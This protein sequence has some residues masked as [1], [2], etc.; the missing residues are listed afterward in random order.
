M[1]KGSRH[2]ESL[3]TPGSIQASLEGNNQ[4]HALKDGWGSS[5]PVEKT[6]YLINE[7]RRAVVVGHGPRASRK[8]TKLNGLKRRSRILNW[9]MIF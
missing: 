5:A 8:P 3:E 2:L 4:K 6:D 9:K 7:A 1:S